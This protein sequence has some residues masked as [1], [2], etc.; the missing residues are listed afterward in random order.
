MAAHSTEV[1][2]VGH[3]PVQKSLQ[4]LQSEA[5]QFGDIDRGRPAAAAKLLRSPLASG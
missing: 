5:L 1:P 3:H 2:R 4:K